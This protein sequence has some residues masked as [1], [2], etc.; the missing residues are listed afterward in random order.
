MHLDFWGIGLPGILAGLVIAALF[1]WLR[2]LSRQR[3]AELARR[4]ADEVMARQKAE[5]SA[6]E[7]ASNAAEK[8]ARADELAAL[9]LG[10]ADEKKVREHWGVVAASERITSLSLRAVEAGQ[11]ALANLENQMLYAE[12]LHNRGNPN[13]P[14]TEI[15]RWKNEQKGKVT[16]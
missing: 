12:W 1:A 8:Q 2:R 3:D 5:Q 9:L 6:S 11:V 15:V 13:A 16:K 7:A 14:W 10:S 4:V